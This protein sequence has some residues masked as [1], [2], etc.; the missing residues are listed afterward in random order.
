[1]IIPEILQKPEGK[2]L[3]VIIFGFKP[4]PV[5][6]LDPVSQEFLKGLRS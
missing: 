3:E 5:P 6:K 1:M 4:A 2:N